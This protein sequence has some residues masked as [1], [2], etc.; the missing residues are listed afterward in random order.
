MEKR[1]TGLVFGG[2]LVAVSVAA[3][4]LM[5]QRPGPPMGRM[6][7][8]GMGGPGFG[9]FPHKTVTG[10]PFSAQETMQSQ[11]TLADG[12]QIQ[13]QENAK[14]YRDSSGRFRMDTTFSVPATGGGQTTRT[15]I[16]IYDPVAGYMYRLDPQTMKG[17][18]SPI[19]QTQTRSGD[20]G[21]RARGA[22]SG[23][24]VQTQDL[25]TQTINGV[26]ATGTQVTTTIPAG[27]FGNT[28]QIQTVR[29]TWVSTVLQIP[30][31]V[32]TTDPRSGNSAMNVTNIGQAEPDASLFQVPTSYTVTPAQRGGRRFGGQAWQRPGR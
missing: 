18:Q 24:Q 7:F 9:M 23:V 19:R 30:V 25:G 16:T 12:S 27:T 2:A 8:G 6:G 26:S 22:R 20:F 3:V 32:T 10:A 11:R 29:T 28:Q 21:G 1:L 13:R 14:L 15:T 17:V 31:Q 4:S 5:A